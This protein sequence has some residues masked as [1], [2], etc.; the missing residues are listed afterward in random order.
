MNKLSIAS[1]LTY[2]ERERQKK[3]EKWSEDHDDNHIEGELGIAALC[4]EQLP[5]ERDLPGGDIYLQ[6]A[7]P[8]NWPWGDDWWKPSPDDR[9]K[10]LVKAGGLYRAEM[11]RLQRKLNKVHVKIEK[12]LETPAYNQI[13]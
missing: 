12:L 5:S 6:T 11:E 9:L 13:Y 2:D 10:E 4:Y 7:M 8:N 1:K 3:V